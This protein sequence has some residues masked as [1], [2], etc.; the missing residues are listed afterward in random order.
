M[1][2]RGSIL[3]G[4]TGRLHATLCPS[5]LQTVTTGG[6]NPQ[7][8]FLTVLDVECVDTKV[9]NISVGVE[10]YN[11][12]R[13]TPILFAA[14]YYAC[15][16]QIVASLNNPGLIGSYHYQ[17]IVIISSTDHA[18]SVWMYNHGN[19]NAIWRFSLHSR[20]AQIL[21]RWVAHERGFL[22]SG[23][24]VFFCENCCLVLECSPGKQQLRKI[25]WD[26]GGNHGLNGGVVDVLP[27]MG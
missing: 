14:T 15:I 20:S 27:R 7:D 25:L 22:V 4:V 5:S 19:E 1:S 8:S 24:S 13:T 3:N 2:R 26:E 18:I 12:R 6:I 9:S 21:I 17:G 10:E 23:E 11:K 16:A